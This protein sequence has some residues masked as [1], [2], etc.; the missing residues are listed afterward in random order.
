MGLL[1]F[2]LGLLYFNSYKNFNIVRIPHMVN[3]ELKMLNI[4]QTTVHAL[5]EAFLTI[6][7]FEPFKSAVQVSVT[8]ERNHKKAP[9]RNQ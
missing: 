1:V 6:V 8:R 4:N 5:V 7:I 3:T 2:T 9:T